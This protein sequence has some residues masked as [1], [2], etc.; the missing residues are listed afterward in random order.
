MKAA[1]SDS[2]A[3]PNALSMST[4]RDSR[5]RRAPRTTPRIASLVLASTVALGACNS[6]ATDLP[7]QVTSGTITGVGFRVISGTV[8][9]LSPDGPIRGD[10]LG[11]TIVLDQPPAALGMSDPDLLQLRTQFAI[12]NLGSLQIA[13]FGNEGDEIASGLSVLL[14]RSGDEISYRFYLSDLGGTPFADSAFAPPANAAGE[15]WVTTEFYAQDVPGY[16]PGAGITMW[17]LA[18]QETPP[19][20]TD[21]VL[22]CADGPAVQAT[23]LDG[24]RVAY[25]LTSA[26]VVGIEVVDSIIGPCHA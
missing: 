18:D 10:S 9:Q 15:L 26:F 20:F 4:H 14:D 21:D 17:P 22:G 12:S 3:K 16:G 8:Y 24:D 7:T 6:N 19:V 11:A 23:T 2:R 13:A 5:T 25:V 1:T